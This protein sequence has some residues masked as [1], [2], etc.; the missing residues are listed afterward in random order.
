MS[1]AHRASVGV[2][3][4]ARDAE[5]TLGRC[6]TSI[7]PFVA[8]TVVCVDETTTDRTARVAKSHGATV[9]PVKVS[10][11]HE[12]PDH[13]RV[14]AQHFANARN[15]SFKHLDPALDWWLW[16]D[17]DDVFDG[18]AQLSD[19]LGQVPEHVGGI[20]LPYLYGQVE[21]Q[22]NT[23]FHRERLLRPRLNW[24]WEGRVHEVVKPG[25]QQQWL[26][27]DTPR[28]VHQDGGHRGQSSADRNNLLLEIDYE[29]DPQNGRTLFYLGNSYFALGDMETAA[30][31]YEQL[32][33]LPTRPNPYELWQAYCYL[34]QCYRRMGDPAAA[35][36]A[37][38]GAIDTVP[39][40]PEP[41]L[42]LAAVY[43]DMGEHEKCLHWT[44]EAKKLPD[45]PFFVFKNPLD[46]S[47]N[48]R[49][50]AS[51]ALMKLGRVKEAVAEREA[52]YAVIPDKQV[53]EAIAQGKGL[54]VAEQQANEAL[55]VF[56]VLSRA[57]HEEAAVK[58]Y[59]TLPP[60]VRQFGRVR[61]LV[62]PALLKRR[63]NTQPRIVFWCGRSMEEWYPGTLNTT[64]IGGSETAVVEI[65]QRFA[66]AGWR[67]DVYNGA[68]RY[69]GVYDD[70]GYWDPERMAVNMAD[71][72][73]SWRQPQA[74]SGSLPRAT[75]LWCHDLNY[76]PQP[77][78]N[79]WDA[80]L[81]VSQW[82]ADY[83]RAAYDVETE[84]VPNGI[85]LTRF[86]E[87]VRKEPMQ[88]VYA[89]SPDRG[90][91]RL[92][93]L[94]PR[95][96]EREPGARLVVGY[97]FDNLDKE[98]ARGR[99][100]L[101]VWK[102][103]LLDL[104]ARTPNVELRGRL[105]QNALARLYAE[106]TVWAYPSHFLEV[107][108]ISAMEA[109]AGGCVPVTS[110]A[111][112]LKETIGK[113]GIVIPGQPHS[114]AWQDFYV[115]SLLATLTEVGLRKPL[116]YAARERAKAFTWD[117]AADRWFSIVEGL[118]AGKREMVAA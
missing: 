9:H 52:A 101:A 18:G 19:F 12:C 83:L 117:A 16:V 82:H 108:C 58:H 74:H 57:G 3:L 96:V 22:T 29:A 110:A 7:A 6:L 75:V 67:V 63:P 109:M 114:R 93:H 20:W 88:V 38:F 50:T 103:N 70:V 107:S 105:P 115:Y 39:Q 24:T 21:G 17:A 100:D 30:H 13:G 112:A 8:Q 84:Y 34:S 66:R 23:L 72:F 113:A 69:E 10:D 98:I 104:A 25:A 59:D 11:W 94:W 78:L 15:E 76:G 1:K 4:I 35:L 45:P 27:A 106:A 81:G 5:K 61:D 90:L 99:H 42:Y 2:A 85:D 89:S 40:H 79:A 62:V 37:A 48:S 71:V 56:K 64:G 36:K 77:D 32:A 31:W 73:V 26:I 116:E 14:L 43:E 86:P 65:A 28:I 55:T 47:F 60:S 41:Y 95:I 118:L 51:D 68:G 53:G 54:L 92:L 44:T 102:A 49:V 111:G 97:G 33:Q 91:E 46:R 87:G 80:V